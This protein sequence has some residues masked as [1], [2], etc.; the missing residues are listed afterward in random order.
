MVKSQIMECIYVYVIWQMYFIVFQ[1]WNEKPYDI[2]YIIVSNYSRTPPNEH[3]AQ[4]NTPLQ[5]TILAGPMHFS[6]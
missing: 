5:W 4:A 3:S 6:C 1:I 2:S